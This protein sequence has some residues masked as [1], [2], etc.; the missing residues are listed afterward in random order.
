[1]FAGHDFECQP[2]FTE[3]VKFCVV[4][5]KQLSY[6]IAHDATVAKDWWILK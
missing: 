2:V 3:V 6:S 5:N 4:K 1:M